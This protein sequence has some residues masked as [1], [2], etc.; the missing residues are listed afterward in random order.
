MD[1]RSDQQRGSLL[2]YARAHQSIM[3]F[4]KFQLIRTR[5]VRGGAHT[6][7]LVLLVDR[8][9]CPAPS[10]GS[11]LVSVLGITVRSDII[12][13]PAAPGSCC[14]DPGRDA[15]PR[16]PLPPPQKPRRQ[17]SGQQGNGCPFFKGGSRR[18]IFILQRVSKKY[19]T[20]YLVANRCPVTH[21]LPT[22]LPTHLSAKKS[23]IEGGRQRVEGTLER[24]D[25]VLRALHNYPS[26]V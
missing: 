3:Q 13:D 11:R 23:A 24:Q 6:L 15:A 19:F 1:P 12:S 10:S 25:N 7:A 20:F 4:F 16:Q 17:V 5:A 14:L 21:S 2:G 9:G 22:S 26:S 18:L 8:G